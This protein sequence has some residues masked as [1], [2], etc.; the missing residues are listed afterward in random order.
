MICGQ[1]RRIREYIDRAGGTINAADKGDI[2]VVRANGAVLTKDRGAMSTPALPGD[3]VFVPV[4]TR[5]TDILGK[6]TQISTV[7]FQ[8]GIAAATVLA[9]D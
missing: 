7:L 1:P 6:I 2:F 3:V 5:E 9:V 8:L 4:K